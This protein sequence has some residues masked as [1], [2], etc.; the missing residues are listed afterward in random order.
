MMQTIDG[1][2]TWVAVGEAGAVGCIHRERDRFV[3]EM[4]GR[5]TGGGAY[6]DLE[7]AK[8]AVHAALG[9]LA[10]RPEFRAH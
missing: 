5:R 6:P 1:T 9:P 3:V 7:T 8:R 4:Y 2:A 10:S